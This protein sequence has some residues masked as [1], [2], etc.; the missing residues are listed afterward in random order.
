MSLLGIDVGTTGC[1][2]VAFQ[3]DGKMITSAY[4]EY[5]LH[6]PQPGWAELDGN[7]VWEDVKACIREA[8]AKTKNDPI[9]A[10]A[11]SS[12]GEAVSYINDQGEIIHNALVSFDNRT[13]RYVTKWEEKFGRKK[14]FETTGQPLAALFT[15]LKLQWMHEHKPEIMKQTRVLLGFED[16]VM[17]K[18]GQAPATDYTLAAR[19]LFF[20]VTKCDWSDEFLQFAGIDRSLMPALKPS[21]TLLGEVPDSIADELGLPKGVKVVTGGHDQPC[22][23]LG[24]GVTESNMA[25]YGIGTVECIAP[26]FSDLIINDVMHQNNICCYHHACPD[27]YIALIYNFTGGSLFRW[28]RDQ[29]AQDELRRASESG[30]DVYDILTE[31]AS[32]RPTGIL[33][34]PHF[35]TTGVPHF[36]TQAKGAFLGLRL[37]TTK[38]EITRAILEGI[39]YEMRMCLE[40]LKDAGGEVN[41]LRATGGGAKSPFWLQVKAD[42]MGV[43]VAVP[44]VS[45]AGCLGCAILAGSATGVYSSIREAAQSLASIERTYEPNQEY[46]RLYTERFECYK[47]IYPRLSDLFHRMPE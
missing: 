11:V 31:E 17:Y 30:R 28:Y 8:A 34:L 12:Q 46:H 15:A 27:L 10:L 25:S 3:E 29:F 26:A 35:T 9:S 20:D 6:S 39:T 24:A 32:D 42:I 40:L 44:S 1:K 33:V 22:Q 23:S 36:D 47:E 21:G 16:L 13:E 18:L 19:T 37:G 41:I 38:G 5:P 2:A 4:R 14:I 43:P 45:E 7:R